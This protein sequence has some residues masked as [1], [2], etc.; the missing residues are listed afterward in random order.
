ME[1]A[2]DRRAGRPST[3][4]DL[5]QRLLAL[6]GPSPSDENGVIRDLGVA[7][8]HLAPV[9]LDL[10]LEG[11]IIRMPGGRIALAG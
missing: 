3:G 4:G 9:I 8:A 6:L 7:A 1:R 2:C 10:E 5:R 11:R